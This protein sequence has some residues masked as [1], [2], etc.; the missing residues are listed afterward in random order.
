MTRLGL[1]ER[2]P[3]LADLSAS[4]IGWLVTFMAGSGWLIGHC[5]VP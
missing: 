2:P 3:V 1:P 5:I 4:G